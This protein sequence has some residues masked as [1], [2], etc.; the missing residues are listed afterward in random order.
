[1]QRGSRRQPRDL[2]HQLTAPNGL[3]AGRTSGAGGRPPQLSGGRGGQ[4]R[5]RSRGADCLAWALERVRPGTLL[6]ERLGD[7]L[8]AERGEPLHLLLV[9]E[10]LGC[11]E[12]VSV[13]GAMLEE[14]PL[15]RAGVLAPE[16]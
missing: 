1:M 13:L 4:R 12:R 14:V 7:E 11:L 16:E 9:G 3:A 5:H 8:A 15:E 2:S 10:L 6:N